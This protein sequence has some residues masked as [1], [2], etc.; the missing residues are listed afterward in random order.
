MET[1]T[2]QEE[3]NEQDLFTSED[4]SLRLLDP[5][6]TEESENRSLELVGSDFL[7]GC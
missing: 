2:Y 7:L 1:S 4:M 6:A 5:L 3:K